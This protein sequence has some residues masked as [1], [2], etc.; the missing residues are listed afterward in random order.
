M[1]GTTPVESMIEIQR[2][3]VLQHLIKQAKLRQLKTSTGHALKGKQ[4]KKKIAKSLY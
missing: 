3:F 2:N 4:E 1:D